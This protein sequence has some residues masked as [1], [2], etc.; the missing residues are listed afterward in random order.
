MALNN[1]KYV[2]QTSYFIAC[3]L[4][5][6]FLL[7]DTGSTPVIRK[8]AAE[9]LGEVQRLHPHELNILVNKVHCYLQSNNW[10]TRIAAGHAIEAI[11]R[12]VCQWEPKPSAKKGKLY[13]VFSCSNQNGCDMG[14]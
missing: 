5:R 7:L 13:I 14:Q 2:F 12:N 11:C 4:D 1:T 10:D 8:S 9:Q 3:R 6:L